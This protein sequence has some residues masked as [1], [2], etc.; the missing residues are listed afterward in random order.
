MYEER[1]DRFSIRDLILQILFVAFFVFLLMWLFPTKGDLSKMNFGSSSNKKEETNTVLYDRIF[2]ENIIAMKDAAKSYYTTP[3][4]PQNVG[5]K[6]SMTLGEM[7]DKKILLPFTDKNGKKCDNKASYVEITKE[8][9]E[10]IL[11]VNLKCSNEENYLL[12]YMGCY[13]YCSTTICEKNKEDVASPVIKKTNPSKSTTN[14]NSSTTIVNNVTNITNNIINVVCPEC[15]P[16]P[17]DPTP[18]PTPGVTPTPTPTPGVT[19]T[20]TPDVNKEYICEYLKVT[21]AKYGS[22]SSWSD[23]STKVQYATPLKQVKSKTQRTTVTKKVLTGYN[24]I[25]YKDTSKPIY[26]QTQVQTGTKTEKKCASYGTRT[27]SSGTAYGEWIDQGLKKYYNTPSN[28]ATEKYVYVTSGIDNCTNCS[29][30]VYGIYRLY[31][32]SAT[33]GSHEVTYCTGYTTVETPLYTTVNVLTGYGTSERR[34]PVYKEQKVQEDV[35]YYSTRTRK[36]TSGSK[37][38]KW[39]VCEGS[40]LVSQGYSFTGNKKE[41]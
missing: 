6:V 33:A 9:D 8:S 23:W 10:F 3:R 24:V 21:N 38:I 27:E 2:N 34:E 37:D 41:K 13:D 35:K 29:Y 18:T 20:P 19:P 4:L 15:C 12:V 30:A 31:T 5:D 17:V 25:T 26:K 28:T 39:D 7:L 22:W 36:I 32:R 11:K 1:K 14:N 40:A 16:K